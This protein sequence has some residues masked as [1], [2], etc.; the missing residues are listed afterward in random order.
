MLFLATLGVAIA[1][2]L[3]PFVN[4]EVYMVAL[5]AKIDPSHAPL[6]AIA[7]GIGQTIGKV[8]WY[9]VAMRSVNSEWARKKLESPKMKA[10][11]AKW[12][13]RTESNPWVAGGVMFA[14]AFAGIPPL[15]AMAVVAGAIRMPMW[16]F[17]P[18]TLVGRTLRFYLILI[19]G[20]FVGEG[21]D[22]FTGLW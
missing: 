3:L 15:L 20:D 17:V 14:A 9:V 12:H 22:W 4:I 6:Y 16:V 18:T 13:A 8:V 2:A 21:W 11:I 7:G 19:G 10:S 1:S 5:G